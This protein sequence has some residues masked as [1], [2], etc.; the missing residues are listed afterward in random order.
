MSRPLLEAYNAMW[1]AGRELESGAP[2]AALPSMYAALAAIQKARAA[3]RLYLRGAQRA[4]VVDLARVRLAGRERGV[5]LVREPL[6]PL[7]APGQALWQRVVGAVGRPSAA[8]AVDSLLVL[9]V[10]AAGDA[11]VTQALD[12]LVAGIRAGRDVTSTVVLVRERLG[13]AGAVRAPTGWRPVP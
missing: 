7:A 8:E 6:A 10:S 4:V 2:R 9:R 5:D 11:G 3:E 12:S 13:G 1:D